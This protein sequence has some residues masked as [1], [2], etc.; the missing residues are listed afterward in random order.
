MCIAC[1][2][3]TD[4]EYVLKF[5]QFHSIALCSTKPFFEDL[6]KIYLES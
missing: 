1:K 6:G 4:I 5:M 3:E 2:N